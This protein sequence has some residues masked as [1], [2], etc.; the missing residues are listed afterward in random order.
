MES[1]LGDMYLKLIIIYLDDIIILS[2]TPREYIKRLRGLFQKFHEAG[3]KLKPKKCD[4]FK[5]KI[6]YLGHVVSRDGIDWDAKK[7]KAIKN[8]KRPVTVHDVRSILGFYQLL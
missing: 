4:F 8:C 2:K 3:L 1:C 7:I 5:T 6:S